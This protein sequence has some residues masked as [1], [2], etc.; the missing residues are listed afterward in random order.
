MSGISTSCP[1]PVQAGRLLRLWRN[2]WLG[3]VCRWTL[4]VVFL[5]AAVTKIIDLPGFTDRLVLHSGLPFWAAWAMAAFLPWLELTCGFC[6]ALNMAAREAAA[7]CCGLLAL[8][9]IQAF[10]H[11]TESDCGCFVFPRSWQ[12]ARP[13]RG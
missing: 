8:F 5:L 6:L 7:I 10:V 13:G 9:L 11:P 2:A 12:P 3:V 1:L 4:A